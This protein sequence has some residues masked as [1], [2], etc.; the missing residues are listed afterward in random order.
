MK[1]PWKYSSWSVNTRDVSVLPW[2]SFLPQALAPRKNLNSVIHPL[3]DCFVKILNVVLLKG[4]TSE[5]SQT[6]FPPLSICIIRR[7][8]EEIVK[9][10][11]IGRNEG[12]FSLYLTTLQHE[13][14]LL[15]CFSEILQRL[16]KQHSWKKMLFMKKRDT[17]KYIWISTS[18]WPATL[19]LSYLWKHVLRRG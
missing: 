17:C 5:S 4:H 15:H 8:F 1:C 16:Q 10:L 19:I 2:R 13:K 18:W 3:T 12:V 6:P 14:R 9:V 11:K 7:S